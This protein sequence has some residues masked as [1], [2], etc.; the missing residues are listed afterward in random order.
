MNM[1]VVFMVLTALLVRRSSWIVNHV[2]LV[3][4]GGSGDC[5]EEAGLEED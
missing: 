2:I 1:L 5:V 4:R 3:Y